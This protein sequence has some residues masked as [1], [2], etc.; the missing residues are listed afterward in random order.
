MIF[1]L[2]QLPR[3]TGGVKYETSVPG[4]PKPWAVYVPQSVLRKEFTTFPEELR[5]ELEEVEK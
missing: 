4:D 2:T 3:S 1:K 5:I